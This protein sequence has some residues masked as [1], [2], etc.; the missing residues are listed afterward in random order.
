M[1]DDFLNEAESH[2][3]Q[4]RN[5]GY[6]RNNYNGNN[7]GYQKKPFNNYNNNGGNNNWKNKGSFNR[8]QGG[9]KPKV[10]ED[11]S[12]YK[13]Y[14]PYVGTGNQNPPPHIVTQIKRLTNELETFGF[15][16]RTGGTA[17]VEEAFE[18]SAKEM[19]LHLPFNNYNGKQS[20][21]A[22]INKRAYAVAKLFHPTYDTIPE[23]VTLFL[24]K[25]ARLVMGKDLVSPA[26]FMLCWSEDGC[27]SSETKTSKTGNVGHAIAIACALH[28]PVFNLAKPD[29]EKR[30]KEHL[31]VA[32]TE[33][34][35]FEEF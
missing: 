29:A 31:G 14:K 8:S 20:K 10:E 26:L 19:E 35:S 4:D 21:F 24:A 12:N 34:K 5:Y 23:K 15:T 9:F 13:L 2:S 30:L 17:G 27:E 3:S 33:K 11:L 25:N 28:I 22:F 32:Y 1:E 16:L 7:N 6:N 18:A